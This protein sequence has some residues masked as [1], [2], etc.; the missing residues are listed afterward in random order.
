M[1]LF[2]DTADVRQIRTAQSWG[3]VDGVTT[4]PSHIAATGRDPDEL[5]AEIFTIVDGPI[6][7]ETVSLEAN[8][9]VREGRAISALHRNA[10]VKVPITV[11]GLK[12]VQRLSREGIRTNVT[13]CFSPLQAYLAAKSGATYISPFVHR[14]DLAGGDGLQLV[15]DIRAVYRQ[16]GYSTKILAASIRTAKEVQEAL[17]AGAD[18][19][20]APFDILESLYGHSLTDTVLTKFLGDWRQVP[21]TR[22][23]SEENLARYE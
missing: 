20:T 9:I 18:A 5:L 2:I 11:E 15:R 17:L 13:V 16:H 6:S 10:V 14:T 22:L 4:N 1:Q 3:T 12:A 19:V 8:K 7:V 21:P 23:F